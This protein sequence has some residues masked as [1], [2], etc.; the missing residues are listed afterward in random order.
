MIFQRF[1]KF[2]ELGLR[3]GVHV[4]AVW[5]AFKV[6]SRWHVRDAEEQGRQWASLYLLENAISLLGV[7]GAWFL[8]RFLGLPD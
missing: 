8:W 6:A 7:A 3:L 1:P 5:L 2:V 4:V